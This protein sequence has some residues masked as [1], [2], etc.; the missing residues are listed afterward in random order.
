MSRWKPVEGVLQPRQGDGVDVGHGGSPEEGMTGGG[1]PPPVSDHAASA[2]GSGVEGG[3]TAALTA[4]V[5][6]ATPPLDV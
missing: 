2:S 5:T 6:V 1:E 4:R 3:G